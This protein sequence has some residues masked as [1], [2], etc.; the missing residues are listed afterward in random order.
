MS[1]ATAATATDREGHAVGGAT[2]AGAA[3]V[4]AFA[5]E[6]LSHGA[7]AATI[8]D[9]A[10][11]EPA[12]PL[13]QALAAALFL[14]L[15]TR[16]GRAR[17][18][19]WLARARAV[20][21]AATPREQLWIGALEAWACGRDDEALARHDAIARAW[22]RDR[23]NAKLAQMHR[24]QCGD[25][26]G[27]LDASTRLVAA[28]GTSARFVLGLHAFA[29]EQNGHLGAARAAGEAA[30]A[31]DAQ[32]PWAEH[33]VAHVFDAQGDA[34]AGLAWLLPL[35][36]RWTRCSSFLRTHQWWHVALFHL[37][38][39]DADAALAAYDAQVWGVR[40][41]HVQDQVN[42]VSLL[43]RI[44][45]APLPAGR[46][47][48]ALRSAGAR[49]DELAGFVEPRIHDRANAF[50]DL[51]FAYALARAGRD[52]RVDEL[53]AGLAATPGA[54][55]RDLAWPA[56]RGVVARARGR[57]DEAAAWLA[58]LLPRLHRLGGST[59]QQR[60][61]VRMAQPAVAGPLAQPVARRLAA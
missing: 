7:G 47:G 21:D 61:L 44:E 40:R 23:L 50:V 2:A 53:L 18:A 38:Q 34:A 46:D 10:Q 36:P 13:L 48:A 8:V 32:D 55:W 17:A 12:A 3:A 6:V 49:W 1:A 28:C 52:A 16:E 59:A 58:P 30:V 31:H 9:A 27:M 43:A 15:Q 26:A 33:A 42:A 35:A 54:A 29:L 11:A 56:A 24:L 57:V 45:D 51:H 60:W 14:F 19:P 22:P 5:E 37:A 39:G 20:Q 4:D 25:R 41:G